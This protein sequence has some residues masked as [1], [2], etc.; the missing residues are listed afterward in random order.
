M[1]EQT[2]GY[3]GSHGLSQNVSDGVLLHGYA[4]T[5]LLMVFLI[6]MP[7]KFSA[8]SLMEISKVLISAEYQFRA[9]INGICIL[10]NKSHSCNVI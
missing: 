1:W 3:G 5:E 7:M 6:H 2:R 8:N 10:R 4:F 9:I